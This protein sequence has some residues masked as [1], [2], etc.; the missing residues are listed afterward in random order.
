[1]LYNRPDT[2]Y[3]RV[4]SK[5]QSQV[6]PILNDSEKIYNLSNINPNTGTLDFN[7]SN[8]QIEEQNQELADNSHDHINLFKEIEPQIEMENPEKNFN[9]E[10]LLSPLSSPSLEIVNKP[11]S[12][13]KRKQPE[14]KPSSPRKKKNETSIPKNLSESDLL[15][16]ENQSSMEPSILD[17]PKEFHPK[18]NYLTFGM[19]VQ[20]KWIDN[21]YYTA[22]ICK[23]NQNDSTATV[24]FP[25]DGI[26][27]VLLLFSYLFFLLNYFLFF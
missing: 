14:E 1:M 23:V 22:T 10:N 18:L 26:Q 17:Q 2:I 3:Y 19:Q 6:I 24:V 9:E 4:A 7:F 8:D 27:G 11:E 5:I 12:S 21:K 15:N 25:D 20:A 13:K 16:V